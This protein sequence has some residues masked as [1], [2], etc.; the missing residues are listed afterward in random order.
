MSALVG[1]Q[2]AIVMFIKHIFLVVETKKNVWNASRVILDTL[3]HHVKQTKKKKRRRGF[4]FFESVRG[5]LN[6]F[7]KRETTDSDP[8]II[9]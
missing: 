7:G 9:Y 5:I 1:C 8:T 2:N 3:F 4:S 6:L